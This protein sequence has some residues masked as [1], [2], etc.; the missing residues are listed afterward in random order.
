MLTFT[1]EQITDKCDICRINLPNDGYELCQSCYE[2]SKLSRIHRE[3][4]R[5]T[6]RSS[7]LARK[8]EEP[9]YVTSSAPR[10]LP[11]LEEPPEASTLPLPPSEWTEKELFSMEF[12]KKQIL[13]KIHNLIRNYPGKHSTNQISKTLDLDF[14]S[15]GEGYKGYTAIRATNE[16]IKNGYIRQTSGGTFIAIKP[17]V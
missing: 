14:D 12:L 10:S 6:N 17:F 11:L 13:K 3:L 2:H 4:A 9:I 15:S 5:C 16:L 7:S 8:W 1:D